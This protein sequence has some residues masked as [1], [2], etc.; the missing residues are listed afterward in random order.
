MG[1]DLYQEPREEGREIPERGGHLLHQLQGDPD[2]GQHQEDKRSQDEVRADREE[3]VW[4]AHLHQRETR[5]SSTSCGEILENCLLHQPLHPLHQS[6]PN[7]GVRLLPFLP[8]VA[9]HQ[10]QDQGGCPWSRLSFSYFVDC[11]I[12]YPFY[13][14]LFIYLNILSA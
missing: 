7:R 2:T 5:N 1:A 13:L 10:V 14:L 3:N 9:R 11:N 6:H 4:P 12:T 8:R